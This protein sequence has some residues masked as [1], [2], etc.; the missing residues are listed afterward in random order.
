MACMAV[1]DQNHVGHKGKTNNPPS[2]RCCL[3]VSGFVSAIDTPRK[4]RAFVQ[5][6][7][8]QPRVCRAL[9]GQLLSTHLM[10]VH[11]LRLILS[12]I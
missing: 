2:R 12:K 6:A 9:N 7:V 10:D 8:Q 5:L 11:G 4:L 1:F 3:H